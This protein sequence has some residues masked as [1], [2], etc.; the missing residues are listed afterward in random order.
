MS[1]YKLLE[2]VIE[3]TPPKREPLSIRWVSYE[4]Q[5]AEQPAYDVFGW[6]FD[7]EEYCGN[8][9]DNEDGSIEVNWI[10]V[11]PYDRPVHLIIRKR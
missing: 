5:Q 9:Y 1:K 10:D 8:A 11:E 6:F 3:N 2:K 4:A 7:E